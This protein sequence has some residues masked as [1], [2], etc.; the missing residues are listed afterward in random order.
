MAETYGIIEPTSPEE[1]EAKMKEIEENDPELFN[2][3][4]PNAVY[5]GLR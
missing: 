4:F 1:M 5:E 2:R 3:K